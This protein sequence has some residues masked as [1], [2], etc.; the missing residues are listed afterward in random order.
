M[1]N[2]TII[3]NMKYITEEKACLI[4]KKFLKENKFNFDVIKR[5]YGFVVK[6]NWLSMLIAIKGTIDED[7]MS[8]NYNIVLNDNVKEINLILKKLNDFGYN[9][10]IKNVIICDVKKDVLM[11]KHIIGPIEKVEE[12]DITKS[13]KSF[14]SDEIKSIL[15]K[16]DDESI[17]SES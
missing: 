5:T 13:V 1:K 17:S 9:S 12:N 2:I 8:I 7:I 14:F 16:L 6:E 3:N 10:L 15:I 4:I 11:I